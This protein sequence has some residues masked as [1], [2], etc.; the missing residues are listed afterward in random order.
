MIFI[1]ILITIPIFIGFGIITGYRINKK[2][3]AIPIQFVDENDKEKVLKENNIEIN[4]ETKCDICGE[5]I[6][7]ENLGAIKPTSS[8]IIFICSKSKC[9]HSSI[10]ISPKL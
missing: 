1:Y 4:K 2:K 6:T 7:L 5:K 3:I 10:I 9:M 8:G